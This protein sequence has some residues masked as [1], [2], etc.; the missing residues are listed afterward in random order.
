MSEPHRPAT[1]RRLSLEALGQA[2]QHEHEHDR[3][4][5]LDRDL[6]E[7]EV[8]R[9]RQHEQP[10]HRVAGDAQEHGGGEP[11]ADDRRAE[12]GDDEDDRDRRLARG[13]RAAASPASP[14]RRA[15]RRPEGPRR[16]RRMTPAYTGSDPFWTNPGDP[17]RA[18]AEAAQRREVDLAAARHRAAPRQHGLRPIDRARHSATPPARVSDGQRE[19]QRR[20]RATATGAPSGASA[21]YPA[22]EAV[23]N[24]VGD[25]RGDAEHD[26]DQ[27]QDRGRHDER[28]RRCARAAAPPSCGPAPGRDER[29]PVEPHRVRDGQHRADDHDGQHGEVAS[30][31][32]AS[33]SAS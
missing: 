2:A 19:R 26:A 16:S 18:G 14:T 17:R 6:G 28:R 25:A 9:A 4:Q 33:P 30:A 20:A 8:G 1:G 7:G 3:R 29:A 21:P 22:S 15:A 12:R 27:R 13:V 24:A 11:A 23:A 10:G 31:N 5:R 32:A